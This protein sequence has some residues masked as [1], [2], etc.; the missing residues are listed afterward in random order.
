MRVTLTYLL[1]F[2]VDS[3]SMN[4]FLFVTDKVMMTEPKGS[5]ERHSGEEDK[6]NRLIDKIT[7]ITHNTE[8]V[9]LTA[10]EYQYKVE[11]DQIFVV[12]WLWN[13]NS[14]VRFPHKRYIIHMKLSTYVKSKGTC[15]LRSSESLFGP[16]TNI[17]LHLLWTWLLFQCVSMSLCWCPPHIHY[18]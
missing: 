17:I 5:T 18:H 10:G 1:R 6:L 14:L 13:S 16:A 4:W 11:P 12:M 3:D 7:F 8:T 15:K 9:T 2:P